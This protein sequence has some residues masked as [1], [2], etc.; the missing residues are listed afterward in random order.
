MRDLERDAIDAYEA[1]Q[2]RLGLVQEAW[3]A[4]GRP[5]LHT[6]SRGGLM[7]HPLL[8]ALQSA[9]KHALRM[10]RSVSRPR[11]GRPPEAVPLPLPSSSRVRQ[12]SRVCSPDSNG[13]EIS[14]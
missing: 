2:E 12:A 5:V 7:P 4:A 1:S 10:R 13:A 8:R 9:E 11:M 14:A 3:E 6:G